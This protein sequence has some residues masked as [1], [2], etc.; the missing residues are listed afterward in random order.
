MRQHVNEHMPKTPN[1]FLTHYSRLYPGIWNRADELRSRRDGDEFDWP[2][3]CFLPI[4]G[5]IALL[6]IRPDDYAKSNLLRTVDAINLAALGAW[7]YTQD[8]YVFH[9]TILESLFTTKLPG[10]I[11]VNVLLRMP[12]WCMYIDLSQYYNI[13]ENSSELKIP[14]ELNG[15]FAFLDYHEQPEL[16]FVMNITNAKSND[17][18]HNGPIVIL[19]DWSIKEA[20]HK[21]EASVAGKLNSS[22]RP[23]IV[24]DETL[25]LATTLTSLTLYLCSDEPDIAGITQGN[26]RRY[27]VPK[28]T[29]R[30]MRLFPPAK[31]TIRKV[32]ETIAEK[33]RHAEKKYSERKKEQGDGERRTVRAHI[34]D[35]HWHSYWCGPRKPRPDLP[36]EQQIRELVPRWQFAISVGTG[37]N[38]G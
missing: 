21:W 8:I 13:N 34:R 32:G 38:D 1:E 16:R 26:Y 14:Q 30:G 19:G 18:L 29:K 25:D 12:Q 27:P 37:D 31:P 35:A 28:K 24:D 6:D 23:F 15:F 20:M 2:Q 7:R 5:W 10:N 3:W 17:I 33:L 22:V 9:P 11:P 36:P 4:G